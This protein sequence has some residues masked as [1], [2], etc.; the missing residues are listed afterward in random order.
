MKR[1]AGILLH[2]TSLPGGDLGSSARNFVRWAAAAGFSWWQVLPLGPPGPGRSPYSAQSSFALSPRLISLEDLADD[3]MLDPDVLRGAGGVLDKG[4]E[5]L[6][7]EAFARFQRKAG[8]VEWGR[9]EEFRRRHL[10]WIEGWILYAALKEEQGGASWQDW[11]EELRLRDP[12]ALEKARERLARELE[13]QLFCQETA[14]RQWMRLREEAS[15]VG[16]HFFGDLPIFVAGDSADVWAHPEFFRLDEEG[17]PRVVAGVPP[18]YFSP[19]GQLWGNPLYDWERLAEDGFRWWIDRLK[20]S[21][22]LTPLLRIDHFRGFAACWEI[23]ADAETA[24]QGSWTPG[25]GR[26]LFDAFRAAAELSDGEELPFVAEDLGIITED[27]VRLRDEL[28]LPGMAILQFGFSTN[29]RS[30][31]IPYSHRQRQVVYTG[32]HDNN[33]VCGW[34]E[35]ETDEDQRRLFLDYGACEEKAPHWCMI[36]MALAS[37]AELAVVPVQDFLG[38]GFESRMNIPGQAEGNWEFRLKEHML[39]LELAHKIRNLIEVFGRV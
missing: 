27:V 1:S 36:R 33:T 10:S 3:G 4:K 13:F 15:S 30:S 20:H 11:P 14:F 34:F 17:R 21:L 6:L 39:S 2:P 25:S 31:F 37:V 18:D 23:P 9:L 7:R 26:A 5:E 16:L 24:E 29:P 32:T 22:E 19:T 38:L 35:E 12:A 8:P 28:G